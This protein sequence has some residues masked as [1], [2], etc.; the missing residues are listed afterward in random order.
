M[1]KSNAERQIFVTKG[2]NEVFQTRGTSA[3]EGQ[4]LIS[5]HPFEFED[6]VII[7]CAQIFCP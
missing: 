4:V 1:C 3:S 7:F 5:V 6:K 2:A